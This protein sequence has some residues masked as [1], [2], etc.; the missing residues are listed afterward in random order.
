MH[1]LN[2]L[3]YKTCLPCEHRPEKQQQNSLKR[4]IKLLH[5]REISV[6]HL[7]KKSFVI[8]FYKATSTPSRRFSKSV[9]MSV[10]VTAKFELTTSQISRRSTRTV[11]I[12]SSESDCSAT[13]R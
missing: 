8:T 7:L 13:G 5:Q 3:H 1:V 10:Y 12:L 6:N 2:N 11:V 4:K 9:L